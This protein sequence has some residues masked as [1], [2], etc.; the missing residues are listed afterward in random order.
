[1]EITEA[2]E[3]AEACAGVDE[4][5]EEEAAEAPECYAYLRLGHGPPFATHCMQRLD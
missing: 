5:A 2:T 3:E 1:M 4:G